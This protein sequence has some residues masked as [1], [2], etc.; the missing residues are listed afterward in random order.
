MK[1]PHLTI[2]TRKSP[3]ALAQTQWVKQQLQSHHPALTVEILGLNT[4]GDIHLATPLAS[5]GGKEL[6]VKELEQALLDRRADIAVHSMK[7]VPVSIPDGLS[8]PVILKRADAEDVLVAAH[9]TTLAELPPN[10]HLGTSSLRRQCQLKALRP[11]LTISTVR[12]NVG[13]RLAKLEQGEFTAIVLARAGLQRLGFNTR[14]SQVF[15]TD[16]MV[17]A[18][19]QGALGIECRAADERVLALIAPLHDIASYTCVQAERA[20]N[21]A[22]HGGCQ[23]PVAAH[24]VIVE[25]GLKLRGLVGQPDGSLL[26]QGHA[27]GEPT[28]A[29][30]IGIKLA[31][32]L[33]ARGAKAIIDSLY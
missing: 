22:L 7:D 20:F 16:V 5:V 10:S 11:D 6:F 19:G 21:R 14:I 15:T 4:Q 25:K 9:R 31:K 13:T 2:A 17:P 28:Q 23:A 8:L 24:A 30:Q 12:G 1:K 18:A 33:L 29:E 26:I 32:D 27:Q 3:L